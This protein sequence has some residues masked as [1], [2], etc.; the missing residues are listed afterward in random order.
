MWR[1]RRPAGQWFPV[2]TLG[3]VHSVI[4]QPRRRLIAGERHAHCLRGQIARG[5]RGRALRPKRVVGLFN[6]LH[7][8]QRAAADRLRV[9]A[10][11]TA[12]AAAVAVAAAAAVD[13]RNDR[14]AQRAAAS[15]VRGG[16]PTVHGRQQRQ[17]LRASRGEAVLEGAIV[18]VRKR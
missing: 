1:F 17:L 11:R 14:R 18:R 8:E 7:V 6:H 9:P 10:P 4:C 2:V 12:A 15:R 3:T 13:G 5:R 16:A